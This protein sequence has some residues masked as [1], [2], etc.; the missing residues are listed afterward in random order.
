M[1]FDTSGLVIGVF[2]VSGG[3]T[4][5][6]EALNAVLEFEIHAIL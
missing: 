1:T 4:T 3:P 6:T 2:D 5:A